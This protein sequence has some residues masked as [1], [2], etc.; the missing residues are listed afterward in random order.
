MA[1]VTVALDGSLFDRAVHPLDLALGPRVIGVR[2]PML[3][4][5]GVA[6]HVKAHRSGIG[7]VPIPRQLGKLDAPSRQIA[8]QSPARQW[9]S[10]RMVW[11][12]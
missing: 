11:T 4:P 1:V 6:D 3:D 8:S 12:W 10:V 9:L 7:G 5:I 2:Q